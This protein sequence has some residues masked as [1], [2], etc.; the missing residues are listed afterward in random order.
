MSTEANMAESVN[1]PEEIVI[2]VPQ[3][4]FIDV[5][6]TESDSC[7]R[8]TV[9]SIDDGDVLQVS[10]TSVTQSSQENQTQVGFKLV[11]KLSEDDQEK[12]ELALKVFEELGDSDSAQI[13]FLISED[14]QL[15]AYIRRNSTDQPKD[16]KVLLHPTKDLLYSRSKGILETGLLEKKKVAI[17]G[18]GSGGSH[19]AIE[20]AKAGVG[21]F[22]LIDYDRVELNNIIRHTCGISDLGRLKT[23]AIRERILE[24][25]PFAEVEIHNIDIKNALGKGDKYGLSDCHLFIGA[26]DNSTSRLNVNLLAFEYKIPALFGQCKARAAGGA[27]TAVRP[28]KGPCFSCI[29]GNSSEEE[30]SSF[31]QAREASP[32][33]VSDSEEEATIQVGLSSD[34][35]PISN[36]IVKIALVEL[37]RGSESP[38]ASLEEDFKHAY[39]VWANRID[40]NYLDYEENGL[41][42]LEKTSI[43]RWYAVGSLASDEQCWICNCKEEEDSSDDEN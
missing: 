23:K 7:K 12:R 33:Y 42:D 3:A 38:L 41:A 5:L 22:V 43:L 8:F 32:A 31:R 28:G 26:T 10:V 40:A 30:V 29:C 19:I 11:E 15:K 34:I 13:V 9:E 37:C 14:G 27:V 20:L 6:K 36:M 18:L 17:I 35:L 21:R 4:N 25:N 16:T 1:Y 2:R 24:K 39:Y